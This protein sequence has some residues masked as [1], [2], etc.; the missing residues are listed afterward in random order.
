MIAIY[1]LVDCVVNFVKYC[2]VLPANFGGCRF[3]RMTLESS[4]S[5]LLQQLQADRKRRS[6][7]QKTTLLPCKFLPCS[8]SSDLISYPCFFL[9]L[10]LPPNLILKPPPLFNDINTHPQSCRSIRSDTLKDVPEF[11]ET[12]L[13]ESLEARTETL[14]GFLLSH[15]SLLVQKVV[16]ASTKHYVAF[17]LEGDIDGNGATGRWTIWSY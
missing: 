3:E 1:T 7:Q 9:P 15:S 8:L 5:E 6:H 11:F 16:R 13:G 12:Y 17:N 2:R 14:G 10:R 4:P